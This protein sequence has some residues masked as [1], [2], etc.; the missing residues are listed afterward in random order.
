MVLWK[1]LFSLGTGQQEEEIDLADVADL[2]DWDPEFQGKLISSFFDT[3]YHWLVALKTVHR[4][5]VVFQ[6]K[7]FILVVGRKWGDDKQKTVPLGVLFEFSEGDL[8]LRAVGP[9]SVAAKAGGDNNLLLD[10]VNE[11]F[12]FPQRWKTKSVICG[13][14]KREWKKIAEIIG[15]EPWRLVDQGRRVLQQD[16]KKAIENFEKAYKIF[17]ILADLNGQFHALF[18]QVEVALDVKNYTFAQERLKTV[19][20]YA[21]QL[22]DPMLEENV[23]TLEGV[24]MYEH[25]QFSKAKSFF[26]QSLEKAKKA[27]MHKAVVNAYLNIGECCYR[28]NDYEAAL[29]NFDIARGLAEERNDKENLAISQTNIAKILTQFLRSG[30]VS[31]E[32]QAAHYLKTAIETFE[33]LENNTRNVM[34]CNGVFGK[35]EEVKENYDT[36]LLYYERA[37]EKA[38]SLGDQELQEFFLNK[39]QMMKNKLY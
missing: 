8:K 18:A 12:D 36:A 31:S 13:I 7:N 38:Q 23:F 33:N 25:D 29:K 14:S 35:L 2:V 1:V 19:K 30:D 37:A 26:E 16:Y 11:L 32:V 3:D 20:Q 6:S 15:E 39:N 24:M 5:G 28:L 34:I 10:L 27:N 21:T 9:Q 22:G 4:D 17:S